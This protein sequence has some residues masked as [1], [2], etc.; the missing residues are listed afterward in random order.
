MDTYNDIH[1]SAGS[2]DDAKIFYELRESASTDAVLTAVSKAEAGCPIQGNATRLRLSEIVRIHGTLVGVPG[3]RAR[4]R[5]AGG[6][7]ERPDIGLSWANR[8]W[9]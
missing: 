4:A 7:R 9:V 5:S 6:K 1:E 8:L 2:G 3:W